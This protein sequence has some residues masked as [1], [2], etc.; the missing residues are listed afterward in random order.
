M[1]MSIIQIDSDT[2]IPTEHYFRVAAG[3]GAGKT[4]WLVNHI[5]NVLHK[6]NRLNKTRKIVCI[7]YT[8]IAVEIFLERLNNSAGQ[9]EISTIHSFLYKHI[10]KP[11][12]FFIADEYGL[13]VKEMDGHDDT[14]LSNYSFLEN[15]KI[16]TK[17]KRIPT[18][19]NELIVEAFKSLKW[20]F[21][22][23]GN[24]IINTDYPHKINGYSIKK[25]S[26][27][28]YKKMS[29]EKGIIHHD[30]VLFFSY[31][32]IEKFPFILQVLR[33]KFRIGF[34]ITGKTFSI[35]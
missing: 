26:Y 6:S 10:I 8:N 7:T 15:W 12:I 28:I 34:I 32:L 31:Q 2:L 4:H 9:V 22:S 13:N 25:D 20:K 11:Y 23:G 29:W 14:I 33:A 35:L 16:N 27:F 5:K 1:D 30:D 21:E 3:P 24:L 18:D 19:K 17:Q